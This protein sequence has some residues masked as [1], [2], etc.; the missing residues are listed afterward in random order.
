MTVDYRRGSP[1]ARPKPREPKACFFWFVLGGMLGAFAVG[2]AWTSQ[3]KSPTQAMQAS[4]QS[5]QSQAAPRRYYFY[6]ILP[7]LEVAVP[8]EQTP[9]RAPQPPPLT[10]PPDNPPTPTPAV[11]SPPEPATQGSYLLQV[12]SFRRLDDA[13]RLVSRLGNLGIAAQIQTVT[14]DNRDTYHRV[15]TGPVPTRADADRLRD[16][17]S[18]HGLDSFAVKLK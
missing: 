18:R 3:T 13:N 5:D 1:P 4:T 2:L 17:L 6:D 11:Q 12:A 14:I 9:Q 7:E 15:R 10:A 16:Q 8:P